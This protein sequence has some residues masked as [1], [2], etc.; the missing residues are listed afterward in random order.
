MG[1]F[2]SL[3]GALGQGAGSAVVDLLK[4]QDLGGLISQFDKAGLG[5][6]AASWVAK[7]AN[8][9]ISAEQ[10]QGVL[11]SGP[12]ADMAAKLGVDPAQAAQHLAQFLPQVIDQLTPDGKL[13][14][15][16]L[17]GL[18]GGLKL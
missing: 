4:S 10:I 15:S 5:E 18:L 2:D 16:G 7:G 12:V 14:A 9:P 1:L 17:G 13:P 11:G 6:A 3:A 8:L